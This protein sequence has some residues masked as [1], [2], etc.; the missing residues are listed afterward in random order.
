MIDTSAHAAT[1]ENPLPQTKNNT[2]KQDT[3]E[4]NERAPRSQEENILRLS[5]TARI[6]RWTR[7]VQ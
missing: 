6:E 2:H 4:M 7:G 3:K 5:F 1:L